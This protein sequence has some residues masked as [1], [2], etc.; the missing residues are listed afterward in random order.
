VKETPMSMKSQNQCPICGSNSRSHFRTLED[1]SRKHII[2]KCI[3]CETIY[4]D[5]VYTADFRS[6]TESDVTIHHYVQSCANIEAM[7]A[8]LIPALE[9]RERGRMIEIGC[10]FGFATDIARRIFQWDVMGV[11]PSNYGIE[12]ARVLGYPS[13]HEIIDENH[14]LGVAESYDVVFASEVLEH[15][16]DPAGFVRFARRI[17]K[18]SGLFIFTTP[19]PSLLASASSS[20]QLA[21]FSPGSHYFLASQAGLKKLVA[22]AGFDHIHCGNQNTSHVFFASNSQF[23]VA[24]SRSSRSIIIDYYKELIEDSN[25]QGYIRDAILARLYKE[26]VFDGRYNE[27]MHIEKDFELKKIAL[28]KNYES[29][30]SYMRD[31]ASNEG[32]RYFSQ[33]MRNLNLGEHRRARDLFLGSY[34]LCKM[35]IGC[36]PNDAVEEQGFLWA[37]LFHQALAAQYAGDT[38]EARSIYTFMASPQGPVSESMRGRASQQLRALP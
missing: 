24:H 25:I 4:F 11:E 32:I 20:E 22:E 38:E 10:G 35:K 1:G 21:M 9:R 13:A 8:A 26:L 29:L 14:P 23:E 16:P 36:A 18:P 2:F 19:D 31:Y 5:P 37:A 7:V 27:A 34:E 3:S 30:E 15:I 33:A 17:L 28:G 6:H 12:G